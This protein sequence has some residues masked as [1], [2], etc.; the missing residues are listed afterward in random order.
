LSVEELQEAVKTANDKERLIGLIAAPLAAAIG[1]LVLDALVRNATKLHQSTGVY[2]SLMLV[3][4]GLSVLM[5]AFAWFRKRLYLGMVLAL[6]GL[7]IFNLHYWGF[8]I[9]FVLAGAW[10][11]VRAYRLSR[12]LKEATEGV[13][14]MGRGPAGGSRPRPNRRYTPPTQRRTAAPASTEPRR[15]WFSRSEK[16]HTAG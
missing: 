10:Y 11:L 4:V 9:P 15:R 13:Q 3:L 14:V 5:M 1:V 8:G 12:S 6:Y 2:N 16:Q 7:T